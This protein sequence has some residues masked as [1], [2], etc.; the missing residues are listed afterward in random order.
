M[1]YKKIQKLR[2][3]Y[4]KIW[5]KLNRAKNEENI[6]FNYDKYIRDE[7]IFKNEKNSIWYLIRI[8]ELF[9]ILFDQYSHSS[10]IW[11]IQKCSETFD[12]ISFYYNNLEIIFHL[13]ACYMLNFINFFTF[14]NFS[15]FSISRHKIS[16]ESRNFEIVNFSRISREETL[17]MG[18]PL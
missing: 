10:R 12:R 13:E 2:Q 18:P 5:R 14:W 15:K 9:K 17:A 1:V 7:K 8:F 3:N 11:Y 4:F 6:C 16:R